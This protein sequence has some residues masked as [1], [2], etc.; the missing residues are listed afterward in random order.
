MV[1]YRTGGIVR[2]VRLLKPFDRSFLNLT[3][4]K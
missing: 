3:N 2:L 4:K 1:I